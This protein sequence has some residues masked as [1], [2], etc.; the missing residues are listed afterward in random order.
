MPQYI[1]NKSSNGTS[2]SWLLDLSANPVN[3]SE[4]RLI[5]G[6]LTPVLPYS[7][8]V[9]NQNNVWYH[10]VC[11]YDLQ[12][13]R[14]YVNGALVSTFPATT[15]TPT[16]S[17]NVRIG[18]PF[19]P[20]GPNPQIFLGL[21][22][23]IGMWNR[24][25]TENEITALFNA[26]GITPCLSTIPVSYSGLDTSYSVNDPAATLV[27]TP[28]GGLFIGAGVTGSSFD[29]ATAG[30]GIHG[31]VYTY[32]DSAGCV[33]SYAQCTEVTFN[34][35]LIGEGISSRNVH[36]YPNPNR[37]HFTVELDLNGL[38][39]MEV[40][41]SAGR[42]VHNEVFQASG[43][44][45]IRSLDLSKLAKGSYSLRVQNGGSF[46]TQTVVVE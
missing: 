30:E 7:D 3:E 20:W 5:I 16:N 22:D 24:A 21:I 44:R 41:D 43:P 40:F 25:L 10:V 32:V 39:S 27:G 17:N 42:L 26:Q 8:P 11:T 6:G 33:N 37:G 14:F 18:A 9:V 34:V 28:T 4:I 35:G 15:N 1:I 2:D 23:D 19:E 36:V 31:I 46:I 12:L 29:P 13:V 38:T 45:T